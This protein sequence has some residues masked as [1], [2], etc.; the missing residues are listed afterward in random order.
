MRETLLFQPDWTSPPGDTISD[1]LMELDITITQLSSQTGF[2]EET[3]SD[4]IQGRSEICPK[5]SVALEGVFG[6]PATFWLQREHQ[7]RQALA[8]QSDGVGLDVG[9]RGDGVGQALV[10]DVDGVGLDVG[11]DGVGVG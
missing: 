9:L 8:Q 1:A 4:I 3:I 7:Y 5:F 6:E 2:S 11:G 10:V